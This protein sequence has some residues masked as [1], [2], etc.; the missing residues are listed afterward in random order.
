MERERE[1]DSRKSGIGFNLVA[2]QHRANPERD[3]GEDGDR[4]Q[5][6][7]EEKKGWMEERDMEKH[8]KERERERGERRD[9]V[10]SK[11]SRDGNAHRDSNQK[12]VGT[13]GEISCHHFSETT[14]SIIEATSRAAKRKTKNQNK[15]FDIPRRH[16]DRN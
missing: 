13:S 12:Y 3:G 15:Y 1:R 7:E 6:N 9:S 4:E 10:N 2:N 16:G 14:R 5:E 8:E 11:R